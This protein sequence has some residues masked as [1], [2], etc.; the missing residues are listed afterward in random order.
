M[1]WSC[2]C[3]FADV[4]HDGDDD[5]M[6]SSYGQAFS[7]AVMSRMFLNNGGFFSEYNP[8]AQI[9]GNPNIAP[10]SGAGFLEGQHQTNTTDTTG[11][12]HDIANVSLD[13]DFADFDGDFDNDIQA[14]SR[15]TQQRIFQSRWYENGESYGNEVATTRLYRDVTG[16]WLLGPGGLAQLPGANY[17]NDFHDM[18]NDSDV[19]GYFLGYIGTQDRWAVNDGSGHFQSFQTVPNSANDDNETDWHDFDHDGDVDP[20]ISAFSGADRFYKNQY[21]ETSSINLTEV[22]LGQGLGVQTL[23]SDMG[24]MDNDG[25]I[26]IICAEDSG[27][28]EVLLRNNINVPDPIAPRI[29]QIQQ[30]A[31]GNPSSTP[32]RIIS[33][34]WDNINFEYMKQ[35]TGTLNFTVNGNPHSAHAKYTGGNLWRSVIPGYFYGNISY[36]LTVS[37]RVGNA[38]TSAVKA[39]VIP[40]QGF[41]TFGTDLPGCHGAHVLGVGTAPTVN[42]PE[43]SMTCTGGPASSM[44]LCLVTDSQGRASTSLVSE[45]RSGPM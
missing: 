44:S 33:R 27:Q 40:L 17:D 9:S 42:N 30:L 1:D 26:D 43:F 32:R 29:D 11:L 5:L 7:G 36:S 31:P 10:G 2:Q 28:N 25:D 13:V 22:Q 3:D 39:V 19:D 4:D 18:D 34:V 6:H 23:G 8:S 24:D 12:F 14:S 21:V 38:G 20:F 45:S 37:D 35:A 41:T 15:D 16:S